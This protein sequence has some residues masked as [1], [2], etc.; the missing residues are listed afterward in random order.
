MTGRQLAKGQ[1][2]QITLHDE[3]IAPL[4]AQVR[5]TNLSTEEAS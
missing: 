5:R 4:A 2:W 1:P 3:Q